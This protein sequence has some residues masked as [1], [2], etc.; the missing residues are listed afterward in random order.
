MYKTHK[1]YRLYNFDYSQD[2]HYFITI[3]TKERTHSFGKIINRQITYS[4]IGEYVKHNILKFYR[5][6]NLENP[7][8]NNR[9]AD[10]HS[11]TITGITEW[12]ILPNHIHLIVEVINKTQK[13]YTTVTG[14]SPLSKGSVSSFINH[15]KGHIKKW[16]N[17]NGFP[18]FDWQSRFHDRVIRNNGEYEQIEKYIQNNVLNWDEDDL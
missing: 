18:E 16:C 5:N 11:S 6:E 14:L 9:L 7:Y 13:K 12:S 4:P 17:K 3:V 15:F 2:G 1:Q 8:Q 10:N